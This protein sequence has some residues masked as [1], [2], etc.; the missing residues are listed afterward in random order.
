MKLDIWKILIAS[1]LFFI[2]YEF[3]VYNQNQKIDI[4][5]GEG[6]RL[7]INKENGKAL[8]INSEKN[9]VEEFEELN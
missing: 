9:F 3:H 4:T 2:G 5:D 1:A 8:P 6:M 7:L